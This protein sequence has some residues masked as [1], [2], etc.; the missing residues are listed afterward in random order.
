M[1]QLLQISTVSS[2]ER[3]EKNRSETSILEEFLASMEKEIKQLK[4]DKESLG[5]NF[6]QLTELSKR[7]SALYQERGS[8]IRA[9]KNRN[10]ELLEHVT[11]LQSQISELQSTIE[12]IQ[13][14]TTVLSEENSTIRSI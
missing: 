1:S 3:K 11:R 5:S 12:D 8:V 13:Q 6:K 14:N 7:L 10:S 9:E 2:P 4:E